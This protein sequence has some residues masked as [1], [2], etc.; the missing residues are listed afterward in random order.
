MT[1]MSMRDRYRWNQKYAHREPAATALPDEWLVEAVEMINATTGTPKCDS[2]RALD[3][4]CGLGHNAIGLARQ[5]WKTDAVDVSTGGLELARQ[6]AA[7]SDAEVGWMEADLD[8]W[9]PPASEYDLVVVFRFLDRVTVPRVVQHS[10]RPGGWLVYETF[11][12]AQCLRTD[13]HI[14]S[15]AFMLV[16]GELP[17]LFPD[18][19]VV[20]YREDALPDRTVQRFLARRQ[21]DG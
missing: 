11:S 4:A 13:N 3:L 8:D 14:S 2:P 12:A 10:L 18:F 19:D 1:P 20:V 5:G 6:S 16:P 9:I 21:P 15:S 7:A 17:A